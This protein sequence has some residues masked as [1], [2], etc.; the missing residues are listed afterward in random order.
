[1]DETISRVTT[2]F[3]DIFA[4]LV[5]GGCGQLVPGLFGRTANNNNNSNNN[6]EDEFAAA[7]RTGADDVAMDDAQSEV[8]SI[9]SSQ[10]RW[11]QHRL[12]NVGLDIRGD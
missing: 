1:M 7:C 10:A 2:H 11:G 3:R 4:E 5:P 12:D 9:A 6:D 8:S